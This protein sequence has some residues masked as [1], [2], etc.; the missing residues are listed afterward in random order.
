MLLLPFRTYHLNRHNL[1]F[2]LKIQKN[3]IQVSAGP[4]IFNVGIDYV[5]IARDFYQNTY[6]K[7]EQVTGRLS[8]QFH[9]NWAIYLRGATELAF[10][11]GELEHGAGLVYANDCLTL[12]FDAFKT[13]FRDR[14]I[15]PSQTFMVTVGLK[16]LGEFSTGA[17]SLNTL[18]QDPTSNLLK[19][20]Q[21]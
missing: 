3:L 12:K 13:F 18:S 20:N 16:N 11:K 2:F 5:K 9:R 14:D 8:S 15:K 6:V 10:N 1:Y 4:P 19:M 17:L 21:Q 7:R